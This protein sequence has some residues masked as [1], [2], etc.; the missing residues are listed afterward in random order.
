[1]ASARESWHC[2]N[3]E[4]LVNKKVLKTIMKRDN[5]HGLIH[6][7]SHL[8]AILSVGALLATSWGN[9]WA[10]P[11]FI[12]QGVLLAFLFAPLHECIHSSVFK[13]RRFNKIVGHICGLLILRPFLYSKYRHMAHHTWTQNPDLDPDQV[14]FP[15]NFG[16]YFAHMSGFNIWHRLTKNMIALAAGR[17]TAE[18]RSFI[19]KSEVADVT[20]EARLMLLG[21]FCVA[22]VSIWFGSWLAV[23]LWLAPRIVGEV[24][25]RAFRMVEHTGMEESPN[26]LANTRTTNTNVLVRALYWNMPFHAEHHLY[27]NVPYHALPELHEHVKPHLNEIGQGVLRVHGQILRQIW[28]N[29]DRRK[30]A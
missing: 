4:Q 13:T 6:F 17:I 24:A 23:S 16:G 20:R 11:L 19:P 10:I 30:A 1:M 21:Y 18:E 26:M 28:I 3:A 9:W 14:I 22:I 8:A 27:P 15:K 2:D 29:R 25:L 5:Y 12:V 7:A